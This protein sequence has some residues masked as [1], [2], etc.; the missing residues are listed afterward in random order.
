MRV[1]LVRY[2]FQVIVLI[3]SLS[4]GF[5]PEAQ[6]VPPGA[7]VYDP[8]PVKVWNREITVFRGAYEGMLPEQRAARVTVNILQIPSGQ[9]PYIVEAKDGSIGK[10]SG[11][12]IIVNGRTIFGLINQDVNADA[13]ETLEDLTQKTVANLQDWLAVREQQEKWPSI[14]KGTG[15]ALVATLAFVITVIVTFRFS[16]RWLEKLGVAR[17]R[18]IT[19]GDIDI[20]PYLLALEIGVFKML[21]W[22]VDLA[23][24]YLWLAFVLNQFPYSQPWGENLNVF[25]FE[26]FIDLAQGIVHAIPD[27]F[28]VLVIFLLTRLVIRIVRAFFTSAETGKLTSYWLQPE[29][30]KATRRMVVVLVW[31]F[32]IVVAYPYIPGS[33][34]EAFKGVSVFVGLMLSLGSAGMVG[35]VVG[36]LV[37]VYSRAFRIGEFVKIGEH[38][39]T[40]KEIGVLSTKMQTLKQEEIT[41]PNAVLMG[42]T[43]VNYSRHNQGGAAVLSTSITIG[44]DAPWRQVHG[45]LLLAAERTPGVLQEP[46]PRVLQR[47]LS[48]FYVEYQMLFRIQQPDQRY[49]IMS[50]LHGNIQDTFNEYGVQIMSPHFVAQPDGAVLVPNEDWYKAPAMQDA[51]KSSAL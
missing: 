49:V 1:A 11:A 36:G 44:Y 28:T 8:A 39:G 9:G 29:T 42:A 26:L 50:E 30:A 45:L 24:G 46:K 20:K 14:F 5:T 17:N 47:S 18:P 10:Y 41:I 6:A 16:N 21:F 31:I 27:L 19:I 43:T 48:D 2:V 13:G 23:I 7:T 38:E 22:T 3:G 4:A 34:T 33:R 40:V 35:Q 15:L 51:P 25:L 32:A 12:W 37:V